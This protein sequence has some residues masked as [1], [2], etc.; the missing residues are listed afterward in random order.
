MGNNNQPINMEDIGSDVSSNIKG[1]EVDPDK[2]E[3]IASNADIQPEDKHMRNIIEHVPDELKERVSKLTRSELSLPGLP[4][5]R[6]AYEA[7][8]GAE[9]MIRDLRRRKEKEEMNWKGLPK[10]KG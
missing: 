4:K 10:E 6:E 9:K 2:S 1:R 5:D 8:L 3:I 7:Y